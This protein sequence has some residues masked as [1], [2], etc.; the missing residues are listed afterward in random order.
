M[1]YSSKEN[2]S[3]G[4]KDTT[5]KMKQYDALYSTE[6]EVVIKHQSTFAESAFSHSL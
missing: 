1:L 6:V 5:L 2:E 3:I 4:K